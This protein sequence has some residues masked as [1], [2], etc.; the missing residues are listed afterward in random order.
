MAAIGI[1]DKQCTCNFW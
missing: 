1:V